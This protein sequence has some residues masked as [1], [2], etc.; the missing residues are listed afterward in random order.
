MSA[1]RL[2]H[3]ARRIVGLLVL[4][5]LSPWIILLPVIAVALAAPPV[6]GWILY[7]LSLQNAAAVGRAVSWLFTY[8]LVSVAAVLLWAVVSILDTVT[9]SLPAAR[10]AGR[11]T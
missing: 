10:P 4:I 7:T 3:R 9:A 8:G 11:S 2:L 5:L 1:D 6:A